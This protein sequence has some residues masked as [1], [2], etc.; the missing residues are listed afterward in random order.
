MPRFDVV[1]ESDIS[2]SPRARQLE[3]MFDVPPAERVRL[4][5]SIDAPV[6]S[7][8]WDVGLICGPSGSGKSTIAREMFEDLVDVPLVWRGASVIDDFSDGSTMTE[9]AK[10]CQAVGFNTVPAWLRPFRVLSNGERFRVELARRLLESEGLVVID[11]FTSV[12]DRQVAQIGSHAVQKYIRRKSG[13]QFVGVSCH[14]DIVDWLR[15]DWII[16]ADRQSFE[17]RSV[18]PRPAVRCEIRRVDFAT[19]S[20]FAPFHYM[21]ASLHKAAKCF[22]LYVDDRVAAFA[23]ILHRPISAS[24]NHR[25]I[26]GVSR[27]VTLP[28]YQGLGLAF[29]LVDRLGAAFAL[30]RHRLRTYPAHP[31]LIRSFSRSKVWRCARRPS[32]GSSQGSSTTT[33]KFGGRACAVFEY[34]G[35]ALT[36]AD[37]LAAL[38]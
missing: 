13:T 20:T 26:W 32:F 25:A 28:D 4:S 34:R 37:F 22:A 24:G 29:A 9:I 18:Q 27:L 10:V 12:V 35:A 7:R 31:A 16:R 8:D 2:R 15:P 11:E 33:G 1:V 36:D 23:G 5:W 21:S 3:G 6:E 30:K 17:W 38:A 19:W 14:E